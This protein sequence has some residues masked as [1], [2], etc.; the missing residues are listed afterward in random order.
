[1]FGDSPCH[2]GDNLEGLKLFGL[3]VTE[4]VVVEDPPLLGTGR[5][6]RGE[7]SLGLG[8]KFL[9][10]NS[11]VDPVTGETSVVVVGERPDPYSRVDSRLLL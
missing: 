11:G 4:V 2:P 8:E 10:L 1:M 6:A 7:Y 9:V 5:F 3:E